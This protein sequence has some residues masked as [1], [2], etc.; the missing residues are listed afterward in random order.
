M[1]LSLVFVF[2]VIV[3]GCNQSVPPT[4]PGD[5][6]IQPV[7][8]TAIANEYCPIMGGE[9][10]EDAPTVE[11]N[12]KTVGFCC[13]GCDEK[14]EALSEEEKAEKFAAAVAK[15]EDEASQEGHSHDT[16]E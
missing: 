1:S 15:A 16:H 13:A 10:S 2:A 6:N 3:V 9:V 12:G 5:D 11:W 7:A 8:A 4:G 14:W